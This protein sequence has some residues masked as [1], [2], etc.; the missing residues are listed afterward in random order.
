LKTSKAALLSMSNV[1]QLDLVEKY[2]SRYKS[3]IKSFVDCYFAVF[4]PAAIGRYSDY[5]LQSYGLSA[6][7]V[8]KENGGYDLNKD[9]ALSFREVETKILMGIDPAYRSKLQSEKIP[10]AAIDWTLECIVF[11]ALAAVLI[12]FGGYKLIK[13]LK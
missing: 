7:A 3:K 5:I 6:A 4:F 1:Q 2:L 13:T 8:A 10:A 12:V 11:I 9:N